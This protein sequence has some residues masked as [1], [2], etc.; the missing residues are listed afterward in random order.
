VSEELDQHRV[1]AF[2]AAAMLGARPEE[3]DPALADG[4]TSVERL[5]LVGMAENITRNWQ[6]TGMLPRRPHVLDAGIGD[7]MRMAH[8]AH[9]YL[10]A[11]ELLW[12]WWRP[13]MPGHDRTL[14]AML[15]VIPAD[16]T[17]RIVAHLRDAGLLEDDRG[18]DPR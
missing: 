13:K 14:G 8:Q 18:D 6:D 3:L 15:K 9:A 2:A 4:P 16:V 17:E 11:F 7:C 10:R 12:G 5:F 1:M